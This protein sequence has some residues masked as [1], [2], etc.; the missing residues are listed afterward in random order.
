MVSSSVNLCGDLV[1]QFLCRR[2]SAA[3]L[4]EDVGH[5]DGGHLVE[6]ENVAHIFHVIL[7]AV[8]EH[9]IVEFAVGQIAFKIIRRNVKVIARALVA[10]VDEHILAVGEED[11]DAVALSHVHEVHLQLSLAGREHGGR[12]AT[13]AVVRSSAVVG[14]GLFAAVGQDRARNVLKELGRSEVYDHRDDRRDEHDDDESDDEISC[15]FFG[16]GSSCHTFI[17][18]HN[19]RTCNGGKRRV[20]TRVL[21]AMTRKCGIVSV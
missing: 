4:R 12:S 10:A 15:S 3:R 8:C 5:E 2:R 19:D 18:H 1:A 13:A 6:L 17:I 16:C 7:V 11:K 9:E 14:G 20:L 21:F